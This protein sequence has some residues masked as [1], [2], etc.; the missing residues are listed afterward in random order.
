MTN[1][2]QEKKISESPAAVSK[3]EQPLR[4]RPVIKCRPLI[5]EIWSFWLGTVGRDMFYALEANALIYY[6]SNVLDLPQPILWQQASYLLF[7]AYLT[8]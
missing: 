1:F 2:Q 6:L 5:A 3:E 7:C 4:L 8:H